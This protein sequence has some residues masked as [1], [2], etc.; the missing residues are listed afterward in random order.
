M[1]HR[2]KF[3][4]A[5]FILGGEIL[6]RTKLHTQTNRQTINDTSTRGLWACVD[7]ITAVNNAVMTVPS[8]SIAVTMT[9]V[10]RANTQN[11]M[12]VM[13]PNR[14]RITCRKVLDTEPDQT[15]GIMTLRHSRK[16]LD[17]TRRH[18]TRPDPGYDVSSSQQESLGPDQKTPNQTRP[19]V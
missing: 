18:R 4:A 14:A 6:N 15:P 3:D 19:R 8:M 7:N 11:V 1:N 2:A 10:S 5:S 9:L 17:Q 16:V 13:R 12:C